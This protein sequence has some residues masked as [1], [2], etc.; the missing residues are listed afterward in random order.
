MCPTHMFWVKSRSS[1]P[2]DFEYFGRV[3]TAGNHTTEPL[4]NLD[5]PTGI[6]KQS[7]PPSRSKSKFQRMQRCP[8]IQPPPISSSSQDFPAF[9]CW[10]KLKGGIL[11]RQLPLLPLLPPHTHWL[12]MTVCCGLGA[13]HRGAWQD[14]RRE[15]RGACCV[16]FYGRYV[17]YGK[18]VGLCCFVFPSGTRVIW[19]VSGALMGLSEQYNISEYPRRIFDTGNGPVCNVRF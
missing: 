8:S 12:Q 7:L 13:S 4:P 14:G 9:P 3:K 2:V 18:V 19:C 15:G 16:F 1:F 10:I 17:C 5:A 6:W 11:V